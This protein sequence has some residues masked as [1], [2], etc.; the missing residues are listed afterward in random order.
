MESVLVKCSQSLN[1]KNIV[2]I[3]NNQDDIL[4]TVDI[5]DELDLS[6]NIGSNNLLIVSNIELSLETK[7]N[8][9]VLFDMFLNFTKTIGHGLIINITK[10][11]INLLDN[12]SNILAG[13]II[14]LNAYFKTNVAMHDLV[15]LG[16]MVN[17]LIA[18][19]L[20]CGYRRIDINNKNY[21]I[22]ENNFNKYYILDNLTEDNYL[23]I[24][25]LINNY[26]IKFDRCSDYYFTAIQD[27]FPIY[28]LINL[29]KDNKYIRIYDCKNTSD[30]KVLVK[31]LK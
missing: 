13:F 4:Q 26:D 29:K 1:L 3:N 18:Y 30:N 10:N 24:K 28:K 14:G 5:Y 11:P 22:G 19:Y 6:N 7:N 15:Y 20:V 9:K 17:N 23:K 31:Y 12:D 16:K 2:G 25:E 21:F 27:A 8:F